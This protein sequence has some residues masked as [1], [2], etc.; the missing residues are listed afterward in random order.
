MYDSRRAQRRPA[1]DEL[2]VRNEL[3]ESTPTL[4]DR[5]LASAL[6]HHERTRSA[7]AG[8]DT[9]TCMHREP[10]HIC[11]VWRRKQRPERLERDAEP[12]IQGLETASFQIRFPHD[13][14]D[15]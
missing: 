3:A 11:D 15:F 1:P 7:G 10:R 13:M 14:Q 5:I 12:P 9:M 4:H 8:C 6:A 2:R